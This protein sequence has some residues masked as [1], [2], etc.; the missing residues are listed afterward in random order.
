MSGLQ[1]CCWKII[2]TD[3]SA[4][5]MFTFLCALYEVILLGHIEYLTE[6]C[7]AKLLP[8]LRLN[9]LGVHIKSYGLSQKVVLCK[10]WILFRSA[11]FVSNV[12]WHGQYL[13]RYRK[14]MCMSV[15]AE[16]FVEFHSPARHTFHVF[17]IP[18][19]L[20]DLPLN[21]TRAELLRTPLNK[22]TKNSVVQLIQSAGTLVLGP[23]YSCSPCQCHS[24]IKIALGTNCKKE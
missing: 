13:S 9:L 16:V 19:S 12:F 14:S 8:G 22:Q 7:A 4:F 24:V 17:S 5:T 20:F 10:L 2:R 18:S 21:A 23:G 6:I 11:S 1:L 3:I 15:L